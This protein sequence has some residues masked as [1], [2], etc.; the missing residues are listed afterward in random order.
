MTHEQTVLVTLVAYEFVLVGIGLLAQRRTH[1]GL[2]F[3]LGARAPSSMMGPSPPRSPLR[4][5]PE[6][7][8]F[9]PNP[10]GSP[11]PTRMPG[12]PIRS[13]EASRCG[14]PGSW[15]FALAIAFV[16]VGGRRSMPT[17]LRPASGSS[18]DSPLHALCRNPQHEAMLGHGPARYMRGRAGR[19]RSRHACSPV[20]GNR[21][22]SARDG[23]LP[24]R[25]EAVIY[26][27]SSPPGGEV[28]GGGAPRIV[29]II[30]SRSAHPGAPSACPVAR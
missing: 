23:A 17:I 25:L 1:D 28:S 16:Q 12:L 29:F 11:S 13:W 2:D 9:P 7:S 24:R 20:R 18:S 21:V 4:T 15:R 5:N 6:P 10:S 3:F 27:T 26:R 19:P 22:A 8:A 14:P 30:Y